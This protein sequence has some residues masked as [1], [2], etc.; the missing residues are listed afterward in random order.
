MT[1][2]GNGCFDSSGQNNDFGHKIADLG[3][4]FLASTDV[5]HPSMGNIYPSTDVEHP[6]TGVFYPSTGD[7]HPTTGYFYPST[8]VEHPSMGDFYPSMGNIYPPMDDFLASI[9]KFPRF[10]RFVVSLEYQ[11]IL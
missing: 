1:G 3:Q 8:G 10:V 5:E 4:H 11:R 7:E 6:P 2:Y 9:I